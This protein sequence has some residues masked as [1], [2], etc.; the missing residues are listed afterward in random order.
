MRKLDLKSLKIKSAPLIA[1]IPAFAA[2]FLSYFNDLEPGL[3]KQY[4]LIIIL[5]V[6][7]FSLFY[8]PHT[9]T[10]ISYYS[11]QGLT[12][13]FGVVG[14]LNSFDLPV[15]Q[16]LILVI[17]LVE[18]ILFEPFPLNFIEST[19]I[20]LTVLLL[21]LYFMIRNGFPI[22]LIIGNLSFLTVTGFVLSISGSFMLKYREIVVDFRD[23][24]NKLKDS[25]V[26]LTRTNS[27]YLDYAVV[28]QEKGTEKER[29]RIT[30]DIHDIVGYTLTN[31]MMLMEAALD[32][33]KENPLALPTIIETARLNAE[34]GLT[35]V[36][37]AM[38]QFREQENNA[39]VGLNALMR[40]GRIFEKATSVKV[41]FNFGNAPTSIDK[42]TDSA[43]FHL[44]QESLV[45]S[46][47]HGNCTE[48][49][50]S[51]WCE[52]KLIKIYVQD[53]GNGAGIIIE[54]IGLKG[55]RE[56]IEKLNGILQTRNVF[57]GFLVYATIP[58][59]NQ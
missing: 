27:E 9:K 38:Y 49:Q 17:L 56:R 13:F 33:M 36:R 16:I 28:A 29:Q 23:E 31:N 20:T 41:S 12:L 54:G 18:I 24:H 53:N 15:V 22:H 37:N 50:I 46:F 14:I 51:F 39:P 43:V 58:L 47:R 55:M 21:D 2:V 5:S 10:L 19:A 6:C 3:E 42:E 40:L 52:E 4:P 35:Q 11:T 59:E 8:I 1:V 34:E 45:N 25:V 44:V 32:I 7:L 57:D 26:N 48:V 30:R